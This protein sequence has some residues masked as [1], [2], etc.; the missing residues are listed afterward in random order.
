MP[1]FAQVDDVRMLMQNDDAGIVP[2]AI[3]ERSIDDAHETL[4]VLL[5]PAMDTEHPTPL[6]IR[7]EALLAAAYALGALARGAAGGGYAVHLGGNRLE[8]GARFERLRQSAADT[9]A[10]AWQTLAPFLIQPPPIPPAAAT[11]S[12]PVLGTE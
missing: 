9:E 10:E 7:G 4:L 12:R 2:D 8:A 3:I 1:N 11:P 5:L 6:L